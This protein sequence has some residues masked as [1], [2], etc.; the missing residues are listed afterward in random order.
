MP[1]VLRRSADVIQFLANAGCYGKNLRVH[2][3]TKS[4]MKILLHR[5]ALRELPQ[6]RVGCSRSRRARSPGTSAR[7][8]E[9]ENFGGQALVERL[10]AEYPALRG[11]GRRR[12]RRSRGFPSRRRCAWRSTTSG[13]SIRGTSSAEKLRIR[14]IDRTPRIV[15]WMTS[16]SGGAAAGTSR[17]GVAAQWHRAPHA[18]KPGHHAVARGAAARRGAARR[19]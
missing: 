10:A 9:A 3:A 18:A 13:F 5:A 19:R 15:R 2:R 7:R 17:D 1:M 11:G 8:R 12:R 6:L 4:A 16:G 14:N